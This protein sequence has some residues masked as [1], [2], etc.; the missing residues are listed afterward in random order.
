MPARRKNPDVHETA[1]PSRDRQTANPSRDR[2]GALANSAAGMRTLRRCEKLRPQAG[3]GKLK[4]AP[5]VVPPA[6]YISSHLLAVAARIV[7]R[8]LGCLV[9]AF[10]LSAAAQAQQ[11]TPANPGVTI[12]SS[13]QEVVVDIVVHDRHGKLVKKLDARDVTLLED[14]VKQELRSLR[15]VGGREI[16]QEDSAGKPK[17]ATPQPAPLTAPLNPLQ[18][19]NLV[20]L[21]F[22][23]LN[24]DVR[25]WA[26]EAA[27]EF[28]KNELRPNTFIGVFSLDDAGVHPMSAFT[29][30]R[31]A[32]VNAIQLAAKGKIPSLGS[33]PQVFAAM[34]LE[35][36]L[37]FQPPAPPAQAGAQAAAT[38]SG[39]ASVDFAKAHGSELDASAVLNDVVNNPLG[40]QSTHYDRVVAIRELRAFGWLIEQLSKMP[41]RKTV[42]LVSP[43]VSRPASEMDYWKKILQTANAASISFYALETP[44]TGPAQGSAASAARTAQEQVSGLS[45]AQGQPANS[46]S[47]QADRS[48][49]FD[50]VGY[51]LATANVHA[52]L[53]DLAEGTGGFLITDSSQRMLERI[54]DDVQSHYELTYRPATEGY[55]G[56]FHKIEVK[57]ASPD[58]RVEARSGYFAVPSKGDRAGASP[59]E[60]AGLR[61]L[62]TTPL[63]HA[64]DYRAQALRFRGENGAFEMAVAFDIPLKNLAATQGAGAKHRFHVSLL[65]LVKDANGQVVDQF[66]YDRTWQVPDAELNSAQ[67]GSLI[68]QH[69]FTLTPGRY[70][71]ET[72]VVDWEGGRSSSGVSP[73]DGTPREGPD[74]STIALVR[75]VNKVNGPPDKADPLEYEGKRIVPAVST[76]LDAGATPSVFFRVYPDRANSAEPRLRAQFLLDGRVLADQVAEL[77]APDASGS[78]P[79]LIQPAARSGSN[80][81]KLTVVQG[82]ATSGTQELRYTIAAK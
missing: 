73:V 78:I 76:D 24:P 69:Y 30:N 40:R 1:N 3:V 33:S 42:L 57:L 55:D 53:V 36:T 49:E 45:K 20:C 72:S 2:Q 18:T 28:L 35:Q 25:T 38:A 6:S 23:D 14:G 77:P 74:L 41:F 56:R 67:T 52:T 60:L 32:L 39:S 27:L 50:L 29:N 9:L 63:S 48:Q 70:T 43:G 13:V 11:G 17:G 7:S 64:F 44:T 10:A 4:H 54:M 34:S 71:L 61:A 5:P 80:E 31:A 65:A 15:F 59:A 58:L 66:S 79:V 37:S 47:A 8:T 21:V 22:H 62:S 81:L 12:R 51:T 26:L 46:L 68:E 19:M 82:N 75:G 16:R